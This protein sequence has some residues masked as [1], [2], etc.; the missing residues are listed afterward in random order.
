MKILLHMGQSKTGTTALQPSLTAAFDTL[1]A[2]KILYPRFGGNAIAHHL[3]LPLCGTAANLPAWS[4]ANLGGP[5]AAAEKAR[6][7]WTTMSDDVRRISPDLL[8]LSSEFLWRRTSGS[9][10]A[11]LAS[12]LSGLSGD[13]TPILYIRHPVEHYRSH[14]QEWLKTESRPRPPTR[15]ALRESILHIETAFSRSPAL[16]AFDKSALCNGDIVHDF[17]TRFLVPWVDV[18]DL[19]PRQANA[20]LSAEALVLMVRLRAEGGNTPE[21]ARRVALHIQRLADLDR[22]DPPARLFTLYPEVADAALRA[23]TCHR[24]LADTGRLHI[25]GLDVT[26]IDGAA[27]PD[28]MMTAPPETLFPHDPDRLDRLRQSLERASP[29]ARI[30]KKP[31]TPSKAPKTH[32]RDLLLRF[33]RRQLASPDDRNTGAAPTRGQ[34]DR[35]LQ[36]GDRNDDH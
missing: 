29:K 11:R 9:D 4:L 27:V 31:D 34:S 23:A 15:S 8:V 17:A 2:R 22:S 18:A 5:D 26:R 10:K 12:Y 14:L 20:G 32:I 30:R 16:V 1:N 19:P 25:T 33:L 3:L 36:Q 6:V 24:W 7:A 28:W 21:T 35:R 13:I